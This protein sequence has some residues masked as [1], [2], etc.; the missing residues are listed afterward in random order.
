M[1]LY[2]IHPGIQHSPYLAN[3]TLRSGLFKKVTLLTS[4]LFNQSNYLVGILKKRVKPIDDDVMIVNHYLYTLLF[5]VSKFVHNKIVVNNQNQSHNNPIYFWQQ[6]FG[7]LCLLRI[8][9]DRKNCMVICFETAGWPVTKYCKKWGIPVIMD[10]AS[11][12]HEKAKELG[13]NETKC[14]IAVKTK[15]RQYID[16]ALFCSQ[17]CKESFEDKTSSKK[18]II[19]YLGAEQKITISNES[20]NNKIFTDKSFIKVSFIA[21]LEYRKG[22]DFLLEAL[23]IYQEAKNLEVYLIGR[24]SKDWVDTYMDGRKLPSNVTLHYQT[25][26]PQQ[27]LFTFLAEQH[28]DLNIQP[29]RFDSFAMV[30]PETMML[31]IPNILSPYVGAGEMIDHLKNGYRMQTLDAVSILEAIKLY[32]SLSIQEI[33]TLR[34]KVLIKAS[35]MTWDSYY[36]QTAKVFQQILA[37]KKSIKISFIVEFPTQFE[38]PFYQFIAQQLLTI[39]QKDTHNEDITWQFDVIFTNVNEDYADRELKQKVNWGFDLF[40]N[41]NFFNAKKGE[42]LESIHQILVQNRYDFVIINGYK[43]SY[44]GLPKL[45]KSLGIPIALRIDSVK[46]NLKPI[47][48]LLKFF[49]LP[50]AYRHFNHF[51]AVGSETKKFLNWLGV[52]NNK[53]N[54]FS[55]ATHD[56]WFKEKANDKV[57]IEKLRNTLGL[58]QERVILSVAKFIERESPWDVLNA[59][60][61]LNDTHTALILVGDG[62]ER[63]ALEALAKK[64]IHLKII[65]TG[66]VPYLHLPHYYGLAHVFVHAAK[67]EPWGVSVQEAIASGCT[68]IT[69]D[70]VGSSTDLI[71]EGLNGFVYPYQDINTLSTLLEKSFELNLKKKEETNQTVLKDWGYGFMWNEIKMGAL[72][73]AKKDFY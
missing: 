32:A 23:L 25:A 69:S 7:Y 34:E 63:G 6:V 5:E 58:T 64:N 72:L 30:V 20:F 24:L 71:K 16:Y 17:F 40:E 47:K 26:L 65:F 38:V 53:I 59:F 2:I 28:F 31:G 41:Y 14:G 13:I 19:L 44:E 70:K 8:W 55:Y 68:V 22:L 39:K 43:N 54:Y 57:N 50:I 15:E 36:Q 11:I 35:Q 1:K 73:C 12:S 60:I 51:F 52:K 4:I 67:N 66:Y 3:A 29:S 61:Q 62:N 45:C 9:L 42:S 21:N 10:F 56:N 49:Y 48:K 27:E 46:Y 18:N 37:P 33:N